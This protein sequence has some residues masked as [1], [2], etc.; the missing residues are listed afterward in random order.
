VNYTA[1]FLEDQD[2]Q[3]VGKIVTGASAQHLATDGSLCTV[4]VTTVP[5]INFFNFKY[6]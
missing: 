4:R 5:P 2:S 6:P 1:E 3:V